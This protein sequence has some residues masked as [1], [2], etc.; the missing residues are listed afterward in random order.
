[1]PPSSSAMTSKLAS[2]S[3]YAKKR[4]AFLNDNTTLLSEKQQNINGEKSL[5]FDVYNSIALVRD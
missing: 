4:Q 1:M 3:R 5:T 2:D